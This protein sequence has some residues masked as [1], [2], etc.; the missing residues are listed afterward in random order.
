MIVSVNN[1]KNLL[2]C[3][4]LFLIPI[5]ILAQKDIL[6]LLPG[7]KILEYNKSNGFHRLMGNVNFIYQGNLMFC[8]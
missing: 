3:S 1:L 8:D 7:S 5:Q 4:L 6:E 2:I